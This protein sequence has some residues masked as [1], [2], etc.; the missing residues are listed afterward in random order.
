V[1]PTPADRL[2]P[3]LPTASTIGVMSDPVRLL[4]LDFGSRRIGAAVA[5]SGGPA[6]P[7]ETVHVRGPLEPALERIAALAAE[8]RINRIIVGLP[9]NMDGTEGPQAAAARAFAAALAGRV[10][11]G[12]ELHDER[13]STFAAE[14]R[15]REAGLSP[16]QVKA[17]ADA[18]AAQLILESYLAR[19]AAEA[20]RGEV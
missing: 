9:V 2:R 3:D 16:A 20:D 8:L 5:E 1:T 7:L 17:R 13:L 10:A 15:L 12:V 19:G 14:S 11:V 6:V 4:G 18:V